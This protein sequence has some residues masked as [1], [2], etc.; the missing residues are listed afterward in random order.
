MK[1][2]VI[3]CG[4]MGMTHA[5]SIVNI[6]G[7]ELAGVYDLQED[8]AKRVAD[9]HKVKQYGTFEELLA[10]EEVGAVCVTL[11]TFL[12]REFTVRALQGG[13]HV[14]CE[15]PVAINPA[16]ARE[17]IETSRQTGKRLFI[18]QVLRF[19]QDYAN[20]RGHVQSGRLG[21]IGVAHTKRAGAGPAAGSWF[22]DDERSGGV[23]LDLMIHDIDFLRWTLGEATRVYATIAKA[24]GIQHANVTI[25]YESGAIANLSAHWGNTPGFAYSAELA[26]S[27]GVV[28]GGSRESATLEIVRAPRQGDAADIAAKPAGSERLS[29]LL[30]GPYERQL[31]HFLR[32][33]ET[34]D[35]PIVT[36]ED[37]LAA[38]EVALAAVQSA[39]TGAPVTLKGGASRA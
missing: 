14:I 16:D 13:K 20:M 38:V 28:R 2:A 10:D 6:R 29:P 23:V 31:A 9:L 1:V 33:I 26:G 36:A 17:M 15:K 24:P 8:R 32:C 34:G 5:A 11:P 3:G 21:S 22:W 4:A 39:Q 30:L 18:G 27:E 37:A 7:A 35:T 25:R 19:F 12:H